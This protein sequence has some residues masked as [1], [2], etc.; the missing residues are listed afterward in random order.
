MSAIESLVQGCIANRADYIDITPNPR[1]LEI[2]QSMRTR[3]E[4]SDSRF[5]LDAG[6][7]PGLP[8]WLARWLCQASTGTVTDIKMYGRYRSADIGWGGVADILTAAESQGWEAASVFRFFWMNFKPYR[9]SSPLSASAFTT[10]VS[11]R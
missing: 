3:I 10:L 5:V 8:G 2:F 11:T 7:D 4:A 1:K 9:R 6:A